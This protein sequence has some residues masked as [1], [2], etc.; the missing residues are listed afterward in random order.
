MR[1]LFQI[2]LYGRSSVAQKEN[3]ALPPL[4][5]NS[6]VDFVYFDSKPLKINE[7]VQI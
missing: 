2:H 5:I 4:G 6:F 7:G 1:E 3:E